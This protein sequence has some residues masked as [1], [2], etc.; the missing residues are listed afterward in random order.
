LYTSKEASGKSQRES[1]RWGSGS[2]LRSGLLRTR[3]SGSARLQAQLPSPL[4]K[5]SGQRWTD[6]TQLPS[7]QTLR[8]RAGRGYGTRG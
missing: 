1:W 4:A 8:R 6:F 7:F 5:R 3:K 2:G